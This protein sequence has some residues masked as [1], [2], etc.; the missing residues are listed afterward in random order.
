MNKLFRYA[1]ILGVM[2]CGW[3][4]VQAAE[5]E[6]GGYQA[7][8]SWITGTGS[9]MKA[10]KD[11]LGYTVG[12][13]YEQP[14]TS[15]FALRFH[16]N[17]MSFDGPEGSGLTKSRPAF[18]GGLDVHMPI[19]SGLSAYGGV[20]GMSWNQQGTESVTL[21]EFQDR[22]DS[23]KAKLSSRLNGTK[24]G[25]RMGLEYQVIEHLAVTAGWTV[26]QANLAY[27]PSWLNVGVV[28]KF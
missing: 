3:T 24:V 8:L 19:T 15:S 20:I 25:F 17:A 28:Y 1:A 27:N 5:K 18:F 16:L 6:E 2:A 10:M 12:L 26:S 22:V 9:D 21:P 7:S 11:G 23:T 13:A 4:S 14:V